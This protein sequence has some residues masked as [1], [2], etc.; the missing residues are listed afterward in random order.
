MVDAKKLAYA[1]HLRD[2]GHSISQI[3]EKTGIT[4]FSHRHP[5]P[6]TRFPSLPTAKP[7][8]NRVGD[9]LTN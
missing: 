2:E 3:V 4:R 7:P 9:L 8:Q 1:A 6:P 5:T